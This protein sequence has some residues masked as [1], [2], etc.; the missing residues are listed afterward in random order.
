[1]NLQEFC[2]P[3]DKPLYGLNGVHSKQEVIKFFIDTS[4]GY[5]PNYDGSYYR[6]WFNGKP[7][8]HWDIVQEKMDVD[9]FANEL[10]QCINLDA[11]EKLCKAFEVQIDKGEDI[12][13]YALSYA[14]AIQFKEIAAHKGSADNNVNKV[15]RE[16]DR[17]DLYKNYIKKAMKSYRWMSIHDGEEG[18]LDDYYVCNTLSFNSPKVAPSKP[19]KVNEAIIDD[20]TL[21]KLM[22]YRKNRT[23]VDNNNSM[24]IG[25][26]G[27]GKTL[28]IQHLFLESASKYLETRL[29]PVIVSLR[30]VTWG[31]DD[32][33]P[34]ITRAFKH[35]DVAIE[36]ADVEALM[37]DGRCQLLLDGLDEIDEIYV[38]QF[39]KQLQ[40]TIDK[41]DEIQVVLATRECY[42]RKGIHRFS[43]FYLIEFNSMQTEQLVI[44]LLGAECSEEGKQKIM[45]FIYKG[46]LGKN[47]VF[48]KNPML[49]TFIVENRYKLQEYFKNHYKFYEQAYKTILEGHDA[50]KNAYNRIFHSVDDAEDFTN[51][52]REFCAISYM[53]MVFQ[54]DNDS[55][56]EYFKKLKTV[57]ELPNKHKIK[58]ATFYHDVCAT[59]CMMYQENSKILYIDH[60]FQEY[61]FVAYYRAG[62][63][64]IGKGVGR[65]LMARSLKSYNNRNAFDML[66]ASSEEKMEVC[67]FKPY[68]DFVFRG[69][70]D[71]QAFRYFIITGYD[72]LY[73]SVI[74]EPLL[75]EYQIKVG[76]GSVARIECVNEPKTI[77]LSMLLE[78]LGEPDSFSFTA[79]EKPEGCDEFST[80]SIIA[81]KQD[82]ADE[83]LMRAVSQEEF[84]KRDSFERLRNVENCVRD[85][86]AQIVCFGHEYEVD[87]DAIGRDADKFV[88]LFSLMKTKKESVVKTFEKIKEYYGKINRKQHKNR[89]K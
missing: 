83:L 75:M 71:E 67:L 12:D 4:L 69:R 18:E 56:E 81:D 8:N 45:D 36:Q 57:N 86:D 50:D 65:T 35:F 13:E 73:Y 2:K 53:D 31:D 26:G 23:G 54:F 11:G 82:D 79:K 30:Y 17:G 64:D 59:A 16:Y 78:K 25:N 33:V 62:N 61:L 32:L 1:M 34:C 48:V 42:A 60:G 40:E 5:D 88:A 84:E 47:S 44:N 80:M 7:F 63:T 70:D 37:H 49:I 6:K 21:E 46:F 41:Y 20:A 10:R 89:F 29:V 55:F 76:C 77:I 39:Q 43:K 66:M 19:G 27:I 68:L 87:T 51:V 15:Y 22:D 28:M 9:R 52:F 3:F 72:K 14:L 85:E 58:K 38:K 24:L 74:N